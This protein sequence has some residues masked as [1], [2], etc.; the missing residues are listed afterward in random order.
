MDTSETSTFHPTTFENDEDM[1]QEQGDQ[2]EERDREHNQANHD[3]L[4]ANESVQSTNEI[5]SD[6]DNSGNESEKSDMFDVC[7]SIDEGDVDGKRV[8]S[9]DLASQK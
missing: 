6:L 4:I 9:K 3:N 1:E 7:E 2:D 8:R 5:D